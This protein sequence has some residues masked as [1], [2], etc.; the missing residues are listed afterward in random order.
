MNKIKG[1]LAEPS[2][3]AGFAGILEGVKLVFPHY[4]GLITG[5]QAIAGGLA[6]LVREQG[7]SGGR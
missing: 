1:R 5:V 3:W 6:V 4:A 7:A 2:T